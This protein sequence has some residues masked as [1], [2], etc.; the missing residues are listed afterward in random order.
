MQRLGDR[1]A[2]SQDNSGIDITYTSSS[3]EN[4]NII[5]V[6]EKAS[7]QLKC[8]EDKV[9]EDD[10]LDIGLSLEEDDKGE[11]ID[12]EQETFR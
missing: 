8:A 3:K 4:R 12:T 9:C 5:G 10:N 7:H 11:E 2:T 6:S 1:E